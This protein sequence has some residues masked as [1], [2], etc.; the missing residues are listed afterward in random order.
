MAYKLTDSENNVQYS[1]NYHWKFTLS[2]WKMIKDQIKIAYS[3]MI[4]DHIKIIEIMIFW[5]D[6]ICIDIIG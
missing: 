3:M 5:S 6:L 4:W 2:T 1:L